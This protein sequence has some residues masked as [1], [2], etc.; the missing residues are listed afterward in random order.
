M[1]R[2]NPQTARRGRRAHLDSVVLVLKSSL[3]LLQSL[4]Q[5]LLHINQITVQNTCNYNTHMMDWLQLLSLV[6]EYTHDGLA[7]AIV[8]GL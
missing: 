4:C 8:T 7:T 1:K 2:V 5:S 3:I 6:C